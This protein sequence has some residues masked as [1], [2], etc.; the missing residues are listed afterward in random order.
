MVK[1]TKDLK[2]T[3]TNP[4]LITEG[5]LEKLNENLTRFGDLG[6]VI[7][8]VQLKELVSGNQRTS[9]FN[10]KSKNKI[11]YT[12][13]LK[14]P[15]EDGT[16]AYGYI[17]V[18]NQKFSY[19]EVEWEEE[20]HKAAVLLAN[21][22]AGKFDFLMLETEFANIDFEGLGMDDLK[23]DLDRFVYGEESSENE[24][25]QDDEDVDLS[26]FFEEDTEGKN[27][28]PKLKII[29]EYVEEE[30]E[31]VKNALAKIAQTPEASVWKLLEL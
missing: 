3:K 23:A 12:E 31:L 13:Q 5:A 15:T 29:L 27:K 21:T 17:I 10:L 4:R 28:I 16:T 18:D 11:E 8:N 24:V 7:Y 19:R 6:G 14:T 22:H 2:K 9:L 25:H 1:S 20:K 30:Y 26:Q